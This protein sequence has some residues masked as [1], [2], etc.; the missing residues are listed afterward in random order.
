MFSLTTGF[1]VDSQ[2]FPNVDLLRI[3]AVGCIWCLYRAAPLILP[4]IKT[5][6]KLFQVFLCSAVSA[7]SFLPLPLISHLRPPQKGEHTL[8]KAL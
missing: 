6:D 4:G 8:S 7:K 2:S 1:K 5:Q 3:S